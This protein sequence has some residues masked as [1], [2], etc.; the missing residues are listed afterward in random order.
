[1]H[2][3][4]KPAC[5]TQI[6]INI[7]NPHA[8][9]MRSQ[10]PSLLIIHLTVTVLTAVELSRPPPWDCVGRTRVSRFTFSEH[11]LI[12]VVPPSM[13]PSMISTPNTRHINTTVDT[14]ITVGNCR[15]M[16]VWA[17]GRVWLQARKYNG[18]KEGWRIVR[19]GRSACKWIWNT[20]Q[21]VVNL[22]VPFQNTAWFLHA[23]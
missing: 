7:G 2:M 19:G 18:M 14:D 5:A 23:A 11:A 1:M 17:L 20:V 6:E 8:C 15:K 22:H 16:S 4:Y 3:L 13:S 21:L 12:H 9:I 10:H